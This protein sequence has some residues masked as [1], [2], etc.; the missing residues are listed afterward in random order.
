[1]GD[2]GSLTSMQVLQEPLFYNLQ[3]RDP[4]DQFLVGLGDRWGDLVSRGITRVGDLA[5]ALA[6]GPGQVTDLLPSLLALYQA[7]PAPWK[8]VVSTPPDLSTADWIWDPT[9]PH[10]VFANSS[11]HPYLPYSISPS[12]TISVCWPAPQQPD[13]SVSSPALVWEWDAARPWHPASKRK[14]QSSRKS[15]YFIGGGDS[16]VVDPRVWGFG[17]EPSHQYVVREAAARLCLIRM[18]REDSNFIPGTP[19]R[20][21]IWEDNWE[22]TTPAFCWRVRSSNNCGLEGLLALPPLR[23]L[24]GR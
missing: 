12:G 15:F 10:L 3:V 24:D 14:L 6:P 19:L 17:E 20:P 13:L 23:S 18:P 2:S 8:A 21:P 5:R 1:M 22:S 9:T 11:M 4:S 7:L 16:A